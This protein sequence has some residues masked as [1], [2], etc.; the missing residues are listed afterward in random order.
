MQGIGT[1][2]VEEELKVLF[3]R[4]RVLRMDLDTTTRKGAHDTLLRKFGNREADI[5]LG[6]QMVAKG[7][8]FAHVTLV[9]VVSADTQMLLPDF[10]AAERTFQLLTQVAGRAGRSTLHGEVVI[11]THQPNHYAL[12]HVPTHNVVGFIEEEITQ[13]QE[14]EY[15][16]FSRLVLLEST[17]ESEERV[18]ET[19][20]Q[21]KELLDRRGGPFTI[22]GPA[23]AVIPRLRKQWRWH[24][25]IKNTKRSDPSGAKLRDV[26]HAMVQSLATGGR[27]P[28]RLTI[29]VDPVGLL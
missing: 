2:R 11:Q 15:P 19:A 18:R 8:D 23:P 20:E 5:L 29:D 10:R 21:I 1:Q 9:G 13:R 6:T 17:G 26:L 12:R 24:T 28:T 27:G 7:L 22:L 25:I 16:P 14:L 4:A 3:P